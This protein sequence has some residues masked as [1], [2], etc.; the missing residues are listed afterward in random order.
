MFYTAETDYHNSSFSSIISS[1][2]AA[3]KRESLSITLLDTIGMRE[4]ASYDGA[5]ALTQV[6]SELEG[7]LGNT[8]TI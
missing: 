2:L 3:V 7:S 5:W 4:Y 6:T 8:L 1:L